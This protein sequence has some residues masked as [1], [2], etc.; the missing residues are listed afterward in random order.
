MNFYTCKLSCTIINKETNP[1]R[2]LR[3]E[4]TF[5]KSYIFNEIDY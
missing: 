2:Q 4:E 5:L 3:M 1:P